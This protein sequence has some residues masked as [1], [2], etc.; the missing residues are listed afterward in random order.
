MCGII[1]FFGNE[2]G[3]ESGRDMDRFRSTFVLSKRIRHRGP[4]WN[5]IY[6]VKEKPYWT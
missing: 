3:G 2:S 1:A 6:S 5:G 4:D